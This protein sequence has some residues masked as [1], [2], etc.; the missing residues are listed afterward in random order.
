MSRPGLFIPALIA[1]AALA[2][3]GCERTT[4]DTDIQLVS[5]GEAKALWD[6]SRT[7][8]DLAIFIDP[9]PAKYYEA[10]R[11]PGARHLELQQADPRRPRDPALD[12]YQHII[13]YGDNPAHPVAKGMTKRLMEIGYDG[14]RWFA[15][16]MKDWTERGYPTEGHAAADEPAPPANDPEERAG[17][18]DESPTPPQQPNPGS[19]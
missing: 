8:P 5:V 10:R 2:A 14:V 19:G 1:A 15:G 13:V 11:I 18:P 3:I 9:R 4:R 17:T 7:R 12:R 16:G 6:R